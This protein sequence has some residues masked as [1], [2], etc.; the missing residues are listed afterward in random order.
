MRLYL[1]RAH[2]S[3]AARRPA[4]R[5]AAY[6]TIEGALEELLHIVAQGLDGRLAPLAE[7]AI[8]LTL[9]AQRDA[10]VAL[11]GRTLLRRPAVDACQAAG[12]APRDLAKQV[13][14]T[15]RIVHL[16]VY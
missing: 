16:Q 9:H 2:R 7:L 11:E 5:I 1:V 13:V 4:M 12:E 15:I 14:V 6:L 8:R 10:V 3:L